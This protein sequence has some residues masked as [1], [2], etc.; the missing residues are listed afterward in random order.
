[1]PSLARFHVVT[2]TLLVGLGI[3]LGSC[4]SNPPGSAAFADLGRDEGLVLGKLGV[5]SFHAIGARGRRMQVRAL[6]AGGAAVDAKFFEDL[7]DDEGRTAPFLIRLPAGRYEITG[8]QLDF[9]TGQDAQDAPGVEF[10]VRPGIAVC[11]GALYPLHLRRASGVPYTTALIPRDECLV[12]DQQLRARAPRDMPRV[13]AGLAANRLCTSCRAEVAQGGMPAL[14]GAF[15][16]TALP[17]L[18]AEQHRLG[19]TD[20][21]PLRWPREVEAQPRPLKLNVCVATDGRVYDARVLESAHPALDNQVL[22][23]VQAWRFQPFRLEGRP[24][25]F[26]Y[27]PRWELQRPSATA[28]NQ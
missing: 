24:T 28:G 17:L 15:D 18:V 12:I 19:D 26:C 2:A 25:P 7:S 3:V 14:T 16:S 22:V 23:R 10:E 4:A 21:L 27:Q 8:W 20:D 5:P 6:G 11:I 1:V 13:E 9:V